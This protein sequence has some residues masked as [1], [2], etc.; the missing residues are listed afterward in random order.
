ME[1]FQKF[2]K[3]VGIAVCK[4]QLQVNEIRLKIRE[5]L[6]SEHGKPAG[7]LTHEEADYFNCIDIKQSEFDVLLAKDETYW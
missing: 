5:A 4:A 3:E 7:L 2:K 6:F 1:N